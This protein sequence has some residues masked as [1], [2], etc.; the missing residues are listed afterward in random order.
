MY[1]V[2]S[3]IQHGHTCWILFAPRENDSTWNQFLLFDTSICISSMNKFMAL[4]DRE[5]AHKIN[6]FKMY[7]K[8]YT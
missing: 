2:K 4:Q 5:M 8:F 1:E 7:Y 6:F 3:I